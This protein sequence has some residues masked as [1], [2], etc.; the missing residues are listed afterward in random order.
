MPEELSSWG[1]TDWI[2]AVGVLVILCGGLLVWR[3]VWRNQMPHGWER[4]PESWPWGE[5]LWQGYR[6]SFLPALIGIAVLLTMVLSGLF[7]PE[8]P[9]GPFVRPYW[10][11]IPA[12]SA[13]GLA[14]LAWLS[15]VLLNF[16]KFLVPPHLRDQPGALAVWLRAWRRSREPRGGAR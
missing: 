14:L 1:V 7:I 15:V 11:V 8:Q 12:L 13:F 9:Q 5:A 4:A 6:R 16:P 10:A 3:R 2:G